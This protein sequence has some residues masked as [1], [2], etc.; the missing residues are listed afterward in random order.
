[1]KHIT[2]VGCTLQEVTQLI[3]HIW[4]FKASKTLMEVLLDKESN[5]YTVYWVEKE[6]ETMNV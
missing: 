5:T 1:M 3:D 6:E 4:L 2:N